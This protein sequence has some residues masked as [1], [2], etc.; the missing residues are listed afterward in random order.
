VISHFFWQKRK[1]EYVDFDAYLKAK[2]LDNI[3][4]FDWYSVNGELAVD[5]VYKME[6]FDKLLFFLM[7][8][9]ILKRSCPSLL[10]EQ[11]LIL[12]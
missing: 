12:D 4:S 5:K 1:E 6:E 11:N 10:I 9:L 2:E 3:K 7:K 8:D